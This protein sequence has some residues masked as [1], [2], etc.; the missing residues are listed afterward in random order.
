MSITAAGCR[1]WCARA[2]VAPSSLRRARPSCVAS[3][4]RTAR[5]Q[6]EDAAYAN[7]KGLSKH[8][9]ALA[10]FTQEDDARTRKVSRRAIR[11]HVRRGRGRARHAAPGR[12][13]P[14]LGERC[15]RPRR[16]CCAPRGGE[17]RSRSSVASP[18]DRA[19]GSTKSRSDP[20]QIGVWRSRARRYRCRATPVRKP[21]RTAARGGVAVIPAFAVDRPQVL[22]MA[23]K[24]KRCARRCAAASGVRRQPDGA[25]R[26]ARIPQRNRRRRRC[27]SACAAMTN[28]ST[29]VICVRPVTSPRRG[30]S[31]ACAARRS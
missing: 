14:R 3:C 4:C 18:A 29:P 15:D 1:R 20:R 6:E 30:R 2:F 11:S 9:P 7:H 28:S 31:A 19:A 24:R 21:S 17:R 12:P 27:A 8:H 23:L 25:R 16:Q 26:V 10:M 13:H 22:L 5:L